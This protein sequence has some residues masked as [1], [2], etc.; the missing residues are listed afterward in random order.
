MSLWLNL[1]YSLVVTAAVAVSW[2]PFSRDQR[3]KH[4]LPVVL[5]VGVGVSLSIW[6]LGTSPWQWEGI[7]KV[8]VAGCLLGALLNWW[9]RSTIAPSLLV[10]GPQIA[11]GLNGAL[12]SLH[13]ADKWTPPDTRAQ[14]I[15]RCTELQR[16]NLLSL[17]ALGFTLAASVAISQALLRRRRTPVP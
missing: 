17:A 9:A 11:F 14:L 2:F 8:S 16:D 13:C 1:V 7:A 5:A 15:E 4:A 12:D 10:L 3:P 6:S